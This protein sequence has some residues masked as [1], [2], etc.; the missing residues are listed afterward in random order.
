MLQP[1]TSTRMLKDLAIDQAFYKVAEISNHSIHLKPNR[2]LWIRQS[3]KASPREMSR[4]YAYLDRV[5]QLIPVQHQASLKSNSTLLDQ[6]V[7]SNPIE[8]E[9]V[10]DKK[11]MVVAP[12][13]I[14]LKLS[15]VRKI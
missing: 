13:S 12:I 9:Q 5:I 11:A 6:K 15:F 4:N 7:K 8:M 3:L 2:K 14:L 10:A 1:T